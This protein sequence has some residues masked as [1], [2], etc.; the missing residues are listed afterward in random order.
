[1]KYNEIKPLVPCEMMNLTKITM[2]EVDF[3]K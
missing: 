2:S 1:M 3:Y